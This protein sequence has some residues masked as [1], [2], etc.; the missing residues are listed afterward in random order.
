[1]RTLSRL[2]AAALLL[3]VDAFVAAADAPAPLVKPVAPG[4][5]AVRVRLPMQ[6]KTATGAFK[7]QIP[8]PKGKK[9]ATT[10]I[11]LHVSTMSG[12]TTVS[13]QQWKAWGYEVPPDRTGVLPELIIT[14]AQLAPK[15]A[16]GRDIEF[17]ILN[18][19]VPLYEAPGG[20][21]GGI[22]NALGI[23]LSSLTGG[24]DRACEPRVHFADRFIELSAPAAAVKKLNTGE[25]T[26]SD[27]QVTTDDKLLPAFIP[28][29]GPLVTFVSVNGQ[30][31][32]KRTT[33]KIEVV[34][35]GLNIG[36]GA[37]TM[38]VS[39]A[40]GCGVELDKEV[41]PTLGKVKELR[42]GPITGP[43]VK[44][45]KDFVLKDVTV[46]ISDSEDS[47]FIW[48]GSAFV[49]EH[50]KDGVYGCAPDGVWRLHGRVKPEHIDDIKN[51]APAKKP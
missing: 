15:P 27:P 46:A 29:T 47:S 5:G 2:V 50:F 3:V 17:R 18:V 31:Q 10:E 11:T 45:Q 48:L 39:M 36:G 14:S 13:I 37:I 32:Y 9:G 22:N 44:G 33:G 20:E 38:S 26:S 25:A 28:M 40:R 24:A 6:G 30:T 19:K 41:G 4:G 49:E 12:G 51:R 23:P 43:G 8:N 35:A 7:A 34:A 16:K 1:M 21:K 42:F